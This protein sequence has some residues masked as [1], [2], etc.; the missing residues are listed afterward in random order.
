MDFRITDIF[1][2]SLARLTAEQPIRKLAISR[3]AD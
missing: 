2:D 1:T 3:S